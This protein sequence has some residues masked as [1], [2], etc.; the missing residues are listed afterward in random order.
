MYFLGGTLLSQ[1]KFGPPPP[2]SKILGSTPAYL[3][4]QL[5]F[6]F[7][8]VY[9]RKFY[10]NVPNVFVSV[11]H[12]ST[13]KNLDPMHNSITAWVEVRNLCP[14]NILLAGLHKICVN[15]LEGAR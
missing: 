7:Q 10:Q 4:I 6:C 9:F 14:C 1:P 15:L 3:H 13:G 12:S 11:N 8:D 5:V 2:P